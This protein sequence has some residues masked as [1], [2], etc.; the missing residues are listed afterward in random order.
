MYLLTRWLGLIIMLGSLS[1]V[2]AGNLYYA[3]SLEES[4][5]ETSQSPLL[6]TLTHPIALFGQ[7]EFYQT[8]GH[9]P[10]FR[11][12]VNMA[13]IRDGQVTMTSSPPGWKYNEMIVDIGKYTYQRGE[14]PFSFNR[15][16]SLRMLA[17]LEKGMSPALQFTDWGDGRDNVTV[18]L[19]S[20]RYREALGKFRVCMRKIIPYDFEDVRDTRIHFE[21]A[22]SNLSNEAKRQL[23]AVAVFL[24]R[25]TTIKK[26]A[27]SGHADDRG[28]H[29][30]N[31]SLSEQR[32]IAV[33]DYLLGKKVP[34]SKLSVRYFGKRQSISDN[35]TEKG[36]SLNRRV[37]VILHR[38]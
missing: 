2:Q 6:C 17:E 22:M 7:A 38:E 19:S 10:A 34:I 12:F 9:Q 8:A 23:D 26:V 21:T 35:H 18:K 31:N 11:F 33:R 16:T 20:V 25:D 28:D 36:R 24:L 14:S 30:Y 37:S 27:V 29:S 13:P 1:P 15:E 5:W 4:T 32:A 3:A